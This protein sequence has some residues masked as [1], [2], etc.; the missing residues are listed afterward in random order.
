MFE[1]KEKKAYLLVMLGH[2]PTNMCYAGATLEAAEAVQRR[3]GAGA[4]QERRGG[5]AQGATLE[6]EPLCRLMHDCVI[7]RSFESYKIYLFL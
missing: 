2:R 6:A 1:S 4:E 3:G 5:I 7:N